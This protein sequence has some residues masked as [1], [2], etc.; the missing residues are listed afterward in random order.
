MRSFKKKA[1]TLIKDGLKPVEEGVENFN[2][3]KPEIEALANERSLVCL[4]C[5]HFVKEPVSFLR[6]NDDRILAISKMMCGECGC[7]LPYKTRQTITICD[8][9]AR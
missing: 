7:T 9:W 1:I 8:R 4:E 6:V 5:P 2:N 3:P